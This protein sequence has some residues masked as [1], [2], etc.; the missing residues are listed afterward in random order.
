MRTLSI[1]LL[2][3]TKKLDL[4]STLYMFVEF[5]PQKSRRRKTASWVR[6]KI[7]QLGPTFIKLG[8]LSSTRSDLFPI[9]FVEEL[10]K[11]QVFR[12]KTLL[13]SGV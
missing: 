8:Q 5:N 6:E 11:L 2:V 1:M 4:D 9:E 13:C 12:K 3:L 10:S 7:L